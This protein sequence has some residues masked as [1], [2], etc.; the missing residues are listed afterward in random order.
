MYKQNNGAGNILK[1]K[2]HCTVGLLFDWFG[3]SCMTTDNFCFYLQNRLIQTSQTGGQRYSDTSPFSI[4]WTESPFWVSGFENGHQTPREKSKWR[5]GLF[6]GLW[7][8]FCRIVQK[9]PKRPKV[10]ILFNLANFYR[11]R[12]TVHSKVH[13]VAPRVSWLFTILYI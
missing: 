12:Q 4:P 1:G 6:L 7:A 2:Y 11:K 3:I 9:A 10:N 5:T 8:D 13:Y